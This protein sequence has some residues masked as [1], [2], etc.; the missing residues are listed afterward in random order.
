MPLQ[1]T[2]FT[3]LEQAVLDAIC[4]AYPEDR[5]ALR[6]QLSTA[7]LRSRE[8]TG[9][10]FFTH[11]AV[12]HNS[13]APIGGK[14]LRDGPAAKIEGI[15]Y[16]MGFILWLAQGYADCLEGYAYGPDS[17][18]DTTFETVNFEITT[19]PKKVQLTPD[20]RL[21]RRP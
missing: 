8:N 4:Q 17:T 9:C 11:F 1:Q 13:G 16:G 21:P 15:K 5:T 2:T 3:P 10:G 7:T 6:A 20:H 12:D 19:P 14:R 18:T